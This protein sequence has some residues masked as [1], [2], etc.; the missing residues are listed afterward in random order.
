MTDPTNSGHPH[1]PAAAGKPA[2]DRYQ[3]GLELITRIQGKTAAQQILDGFNAISPDYGRY[4]IE[5][6]FADVYD[7]AGLTLA[8]RQLINVAV[9]TAIGGAEPQ[10]A[11]HI[12]GALNIGLSPTEIIETI[13]HVALY[14]GHPRTINGF[15]VAG[16]V[17]AE[18]GINPTALDAP[19]IPEEA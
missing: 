8:Q 18:R 5:A 9:L 17:L 14:A 7:R 2:P 6:G 19:D 15:R 16:E 3:R 10:L 12:R 1:H 13:F 11:T 4:A